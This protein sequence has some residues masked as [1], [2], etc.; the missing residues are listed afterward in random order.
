MGFAAKLAAEVEDDADSGSGGGGGGPFK[1]PDGCEVA[2]F[3]SP[4]PREYIIIERICNEVGM[5]TLVLLLNARLEKMEKYAS[6]EAEELFTKD[7][8]SIFHLAA[9]PYQNVS[10]NCLVYHAY[11]NDWILARKPKVGPPKTIARQEGTFSEEDCRLAFENLEIGD[12]EKGVEDVLEN[13]ANW[14]K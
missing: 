2:L 8:E 4:G 3:I 12:V 10:P 1:L 5:G 9:S 13:V 14:F 7:F 6:A 11:P